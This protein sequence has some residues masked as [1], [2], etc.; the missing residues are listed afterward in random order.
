[1]TLNLPPGYLN[2]DISINL[3]IQEAVLSEGHVKLWVSPRLS[4]F[5][6][7]KIIKGWVSLSSIIYHSTIFVLVIYFRLFFQFIPKSMQ[8]VCFREKR[9]D[10]VGIL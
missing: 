9:F 10:I 5:P 4:R 2:V 6:K 7:I 8:W 1:M 3:V